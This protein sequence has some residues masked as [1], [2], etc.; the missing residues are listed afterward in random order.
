MKP[1]ASSGCGHALASLLMLAGLMDAAAVCAQ[2]LPQTQARSQAQP[3]IWAA[4]FAAAE[5]AAPINLLYADYGAQ[6]LIA[7]TPGDAP[8]RWFAAAQLAGWS[9]HGFRLVL[10]H[11]ANPARLRVWAVDGDPFAPLAPRYELALTST[12]RFDGEPRFGHAYAALL[13]PAPSAHTPALLFEWTSADA[14]PAGPEPL[15][16]QI[17][18]LVAGNDYAL[19][20]LLGRGPPP[21]LIP[22]QNRSPPRTP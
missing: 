7:F 19:P 17:D 9:E 14:A 18:S 13:S 6:P 1:F 3:Q 10:W 22:P 20:G 8:G 11:R 2:A 21:D 12:L 4:P 5:A 15:L 16:V